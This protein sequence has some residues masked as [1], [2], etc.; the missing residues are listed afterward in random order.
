[1]QALELANAYLATAHQASDPDIRLTLCHDT[2]VLLSQAKK[3][4]KTTEHL[5]LRE[6]IAIAYIELGRFLD[7]HGHCDEAQASYKKAE[8]LG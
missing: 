8:K 4:S 3:V 6:E 5:S 1:M 7:N 2:E